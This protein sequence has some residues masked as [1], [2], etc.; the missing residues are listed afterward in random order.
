MNPAPINVP[1]P[2]NRNYCNIGTVI[3]HLMVSLWPTLVNTK[4][5]YYFF[6]NFVANSA[7]TFL[8]SALLL[9]IN[10]FATATT[11]HGYLLNILNHLL[12]F[13]GYCVDTAFTAVS[14]KIC[15]VHGFITAGAVWLMAFVLSTMTSPKF[16]ISNFGM[17]LLVLVKIFALRMFLKLLVFCRFFEGCWIAFV[18]IYSS[19]TSILGALAPPTIEDFLTQLA[20]YISFTLLLS[21]FDWENFFKP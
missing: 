19:I 21:L 1:V 12:Y 11:L 13:F 14:H 15:T 3:V 18:W 8:I 10:K 9:L 17:I 20:F 16:V 5:G 7:F 4:E 6:S 2:M